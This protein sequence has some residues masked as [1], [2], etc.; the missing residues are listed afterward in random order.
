LAGTYGRWRSREC[1]SR[2]SHVIVQVKRYAAG[3]NG[4]V[5]PNLDSV[6][7]RG[8]AETAADQPVQER[9]VPGGYEVAMERVD[10]AAGQVVI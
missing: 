6:A 8:N 3:R 4:I 1:G 2:Y 9:S 10:T 7:K 5:R